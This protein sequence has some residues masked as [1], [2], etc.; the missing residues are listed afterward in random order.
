MMRKAERSSPSRGAK[1]SVSAVQVMSFNCDALAD[2]DPQALALTYW[3]EAAPDGDPYRVRIR[4]DGRRI[5]G[6]RERD[7]LPTSFGVLETVDD[8]VPGNGR[9]AITARVHGVAPGD[10]RVTVTPIEGQRQH[11]QTRGRAAQPR[12]RLPGG[13][14]SGATGFAP[15]M[16][17]RPRGPA[18]EP[19]RRS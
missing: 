3:F 12:R 4:F 6:K 2:V 1:P 16:R 17:V 14:A 13:S 8:V 10:W 11:R 18:W 7:G 15:V 9:I 19:G 5:R